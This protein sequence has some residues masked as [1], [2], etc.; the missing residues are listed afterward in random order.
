MKKAIL[1]AR[2]SS[3]MQQKDRTIDSQVAELK[4]Q[5]DKNGDKLIKEYVDDGYSGALLDRPAMNELRI[6]LKN[7]TFETIYI[8][9]ADRIA[10]DVTYQGIIIG[11][12]L[13]YK[14]QIIINGK[15]YIH[16]PENKFALTVL[17]AVSE[18][19]RAKLIERVTRG[20]QHRLNQGIL[21]GNGYLTYGYTYVRKTATSS[22]AY[23]INEK[24]AEVVQYIF[25]TYAK[26][27]I[28]AFAI[29]KQLRKTDAAQRGRNL[30][31]AS[32]V[33]NILH[34][35]MYTGVRYFNTMRDS[36]KKGGLRELRDRAEWI[37]IKVPAII[38]KKLYDK[39]QIR[40]NNNRETYRNAHRP[41]LLSNLVRCGA[42]DTRCY[43][44]RHK[45][46][47]SSRFVY[48][49]GSK[50][51]SSHN[52]E[53]DGLLI[54]SCALD[55]VREAMANPK[56]I[57]GSIDFI[58]DKKRVNH[59]TIE[60]QLTEVDEKLHNIAKQ[61]RRILDL[62]VS[63]E[64][65]REEYTKRTHEYDREVETLEVKRK[66]LVRFIPLFGEANLVEM[67]VDEYC[68]N[69]KQRLG[70]CADFASKRQFFLGFTTKITY[71]RP[72]R[73]KAKI[74]IHGAIP[75][76]IPQSDDPVLVSFTIEHKIDPKEMLARFPKESQ[77]DEAYYDASIKTLPRLSR[78]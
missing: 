46:A 9:N 8:L 15:D 14:K 54:E 11:E 34:N 59:I 55:M 72:D 33:K 53:I 27:E 18:L 64:L 47:E 37:G 26:G 28:S 17:G 69:I 39:A 60:R 61:K 32:S 7:G 65:D 62:Y 78:V 31:G 12:M 30:L 73:M 50:H 48:K 49:C 71:R 23:V 4:K 1:Y 42:C 57:M 19:E 22:P 52:M 36:T 20:R 75:V 45:T 24:E 40:L 16:N 29:S 21:L 70:N 63:E 43:S 74:R 38:S 6:D 25:E 51:P 41:R 68:R 5:I 58:R 67:S 56:A 35:E 13:K 77:S 76:S 44:Y 10:R 3:D 66:E 2:V